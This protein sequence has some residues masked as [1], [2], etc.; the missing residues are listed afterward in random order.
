MNKEDS[1][2]WDIRSCELVSGY[3]SP[4]TP[5]GLPDPGDGSFTMLR[6]CNKSLPI[7]A[8]KVPKG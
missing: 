1:G 6:P 7:V 4:V 2:F 5:P 3:G 8:A